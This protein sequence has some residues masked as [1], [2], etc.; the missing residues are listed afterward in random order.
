MYESTRPSVC[1]HGMFGNARLSLRN[2]GGPLHVAWENFR[3]QG[4]V[5]YARMYDNLW[6]L[7]H[8]QSFS[9]LLVIIYSGMA[10]PQVSKRPRVFHGIPCWAPANR[11]SIWI[12]TIS[13][14]LIFPPL[15]LFGRPLSPTGR[16]AGMKTFIFGV[17]KAVRPSLKSFLKTT[18][19][20]LICIP[21]LSTCS[22]LLR[23]GISVQA[24]F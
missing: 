23:L 24:Q 3:T 6:Q 15:N 16:N 17:G 11:H 19:S 14:S 20:T 22:V 12:R 7:K 21:D 8:W 10:F 4:V 2:W 13:I 9:V 5:F 1:M 18:W